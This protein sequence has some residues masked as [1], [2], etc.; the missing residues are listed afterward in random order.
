MD[1]HLNFY[2]SA[3]RWLLTLMSAMRVK[4][5]KERLT[6]LLSYGMLQKLDCPSS[7][8]TEHY[9]I[10]FWDITQ[11]TSLQ[12]VWDMSLSFLM[13]LTLADL[14]GEHQEFFRSA[15]AAGWKHS[16]DFNLNTFKTNQSV[17][18]SCHLCHTYCLRV[19][20]ASHECQQ[21]SISHCDSTICLLICKIGVEWRFKLRHETVTGATTTW[22][23]PSSHRSANGTW[24]MYK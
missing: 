7:L 16:N 24:S 13:N 2:F 8:Q 3:S 10:S 9:Y 21:I 14:F 12:D 15:M 11:D 20:F 4:P 17:P 1:A 18:W 19:H 23:I 6:F 5:S 22:S